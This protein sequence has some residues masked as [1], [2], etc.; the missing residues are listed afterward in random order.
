MQVTVSV[1]I[2]HLEIS[3]IFMQVKLFATNIWVTVSIE[4][5]H[6]EV[7]CNHA[8]WRWYFQKCIMHMHMTISIVIMQAT[9]SVV[10]V[11]DSS[12]SQLY[13]PFSDA[14]FS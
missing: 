6:V 4:I 1:A 14:L 5:M 10:A 2:T 12:K 7:C 9:V 8:A 11:C 13:S 3:A